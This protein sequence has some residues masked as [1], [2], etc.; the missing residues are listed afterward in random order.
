M[1]MVSVSMRMAVARC[2]ATTKNDECIRALSG[3]VAQFPY[4]DSLLRHQSFQ[5]TRQPMVFAQAR[6][7]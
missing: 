7:D 3:N 6:D 5:Q 1:K 2:S 4:S